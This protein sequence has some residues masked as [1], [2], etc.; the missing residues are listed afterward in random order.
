MRDHPTVTNYLS[1]QA[2]AQ[3]SI[4]WLLM[5]VGRPAEAL[6][7]LRKALPVKERLARENPTVTDFHG[8]LAQSHATIGDALREMGQLPE[9]LPELQQALAIHERLAREHPAV[10]QYQSEVA[11]CHIIIAS[12]LNQMRRY[13]ESRRE[14]QKA[15]GIYERIP[16]PLLGDI[17]NLGCAHA[18]L[19]APSHPAGRAPTPEEESDTRAHADQA[20]ATL[21]RAVAAG[22]RNVP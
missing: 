21:R 12:L 15:V 8:R 22:Y 11:T 17:Y 13:P 7:W 16:N 1:N 10:E 2:G 19:A 5:R 20:M 9:A 4:G 6:P 3:H 18:R 14:Y